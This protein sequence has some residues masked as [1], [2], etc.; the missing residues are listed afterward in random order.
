MHVF[1][2]FFSKNRMSGEISPVIQGQNHALRTDLCLCLPFFVSPPYPCTP[3]HAS[4]PICAHLYACAPLSTLNSSVAKFFLIFD[5]THTCQNMS[6]STIWRFFCLVCVS[7]RKNTPHST[8]MHPSAPL[9]THFDH[10]WQNPKNIMS[11]S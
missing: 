11:R 5:L 2:L 4:T 6:S 1:Y 8:R 7:P 10:F 9:C 3:L